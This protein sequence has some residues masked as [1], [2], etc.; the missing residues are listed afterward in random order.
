MREIG[1]RELKARASELLRRVAEER[2]SL[3]VTSRGRPVGWLVPAGGAE[4]PAPTRARMS[5]ASAP[6]RQ[7]GATDTEGAGTSPCI[8]LGVTGSIAAYKAA[9][10]VSTLTQAGVDVHVIMT[11]AATKLV[12]PQTFFTL[13]RNPVITSLWD[14]PEWEPEHIALAEQARLLVVAPAT[15]NFLAKLAHGIADDALSSYAVSHTGPVLVAPAMNPRMWGQRAVQENCRILRERGVLFVDP[16]EGPVACGGEGIG[17]LA[18]PAAI[19]R[20]IQAQLT[21]AEPKGSGAA[22]RARKILVTAGPTRETVDPVRFI[23]NRSSGKMGYALAEAAA[24]AGHEVTLIS[25]P[26]SLPAPAR[27]RLVR[28]ESAADMAA[29]VKREFSRTELLIMCA[30]VADYRPA[31]VAP[32]KIKKRAAPL[33]LELVPTEDIL[34]SLAARKKAGQKVAGFAAETENLEAAAKDKLRRKRL[35]WI[36]ANDVSRKDIG[37]DSDRNQVTVYAARGRARRFP[38]MPKMELA[39]RLL[40]IFLGSYP[41]FRSQ[42]IKYPLAEAMDATVQRPQLRNLG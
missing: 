20:A 39:A 15:A 12:Q 2:E 16:E 26:V 42:G 14:Q 37:F 19:V 22:A 33:T 40:E 35:D 25:G 36:V 17:R 32:R 5:A 27:C 4:A 8:V 29:A 7:A 11:A 6:A 31:K 21:A 13:S 30:A 10:V 24:A 34:S 23:S 28:V 9:E 1:I 38:A 41:R 3:V 18:S